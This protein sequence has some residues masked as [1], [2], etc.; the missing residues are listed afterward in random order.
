[1]DPLTHS[2]FG[3]AL[4]TSPLGRWL[5]PRRL[6]VGAPGAPVTADTS[7]PSR[8]VVLWFVLAANV[9]D[10]DAF[11][12]L[13][14]RD[15][16]LLCRRG[17]THGPLGLV[18]WPLLLLFAWRWWAAGRSRQEAGLAS[19]LPL[20]LPFVALVLGVASH[21]A[22]DALNAY[23]VRLLMPFSGRWFAAD[24]L[25]IVD[26]WV[27]LALG[28]LL[29]LASPRGW[30]AN[31][32][33]ALVA[34]LTSLVLFASPRPLPAAAPVVWVA[35]L[36]LFAVLR[37]L[38][39]ARWGLEPRRLG[40]LAALLL[41]IYGGAMAT[42]S[43][44]GRL[45]VER[46][47]A[48]ASVP[49][50][51]AVFVGPRAAAPTSWDVVVASADGYRVGRVDWR[52]AADDRVRLEPAVFALPDRGDPRVGAALSAREVRGFVGWSRLPYVEVVADGDGWRV[53]ILD[54]RF[55]RVREAIFG[56]VE[57]RLD[58]GLRVRGVVHNT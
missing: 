20:L 57:V 36:G 11:L 21:P 51:T 4:A 33:W 53:F 47:V 31:A 39:L 55:T 44:R 8:A 27:W 40:S 49:P 52:A 3:A 1:V 32:G 17:V 15:L 24:A 16:S 56:V 50:P 12:Y 37:S 19:S 35:A 10:V 29:F 41:V 2:L 18:L 25:F 22:L 54:L 45:A 28:G 38:P 48:A 7:R 14:S 42:L 30:R 58:A 46:A 43:W 9:A 26:P 5:E 13:G 23:G 6:G 34:G